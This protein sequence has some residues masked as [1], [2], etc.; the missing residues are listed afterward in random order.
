MRKVMH[1]VQMGLPGHKL[2]L[3]WRDVWRYAQGQLGGPI[4]TPVTCNNPIFFYDTTVLL[5][6]EKRQSKY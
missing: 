1:F 3:A 5:S 4:N 2:G 6:V